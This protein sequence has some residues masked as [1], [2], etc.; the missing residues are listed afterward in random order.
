M[1]LAGDSSRHLRW[2]ADGSWAELDRQQKLTADIGRFEIARS[3]PDI[4]ISSL[5]VSNGASISM[6]AAP[7]PEPESVSGHDRNRDVKFGLLHCRMLWINSLMARS[8]QFARSTN[9]PIPL[10]SP[11]HQDRGRTQRLKFQSDQPSLACPRL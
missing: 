6:I 5:T 1:V 4:Y 9:I 2:I 11:F 7:A 10:P 8:W 3:I